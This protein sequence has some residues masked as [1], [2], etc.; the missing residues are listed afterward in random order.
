MYTQVVVTAT[1]Y[2]NIC[3]IHAKPMVTSEKGV[4]NYWKLLSF[5]LD[6][7]GHTAH[8]LFILGR[9]IGSVR[10][11]YAL[12]HKPCSLIK[13]DKGGENIGKQRKYSS[14]LCNVGSL[15]IVSCI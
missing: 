13:M 11:N 8:P 6:S 7:D 12:P 3:N 1:R 15:K 4:A 10:S 9:I 14:A 2:V 5:E